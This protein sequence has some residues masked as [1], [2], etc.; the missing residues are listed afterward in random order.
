M[1]IK[2]YQLATGNSTY[3][4]VL[5]NPAYTVECSLYN[6]FDPMNAVFVVDGLYGVTN[7][8]EYEY[9]GITYFGWF[10]KHTLANGLYEFKVTSIDTIRMVDIVGGLSKTQFV[11]YSCNDRSR[12]MIVDDGRLPSSAIP[13]IAEGGYKGVNTQDAMIMLTMHKYV[14]FPAPA[15]GSSIPYKLRTNPF[16]ESYLMDLNTYNQLV[17]GLINNVGSNA[18]LFGAFAANVQKIYVLP[19]SYRSTDVGPLVN[20]I[21]FTALSK[22]PAYEFYPDFQSTT[23]SISGTCYRIYVQDDVPNSIAKTFSTTCNYEFT[24][25]RQTKT[26]RG[27]LYVPTVG[28]LSFSYVDI[29]NIIKNT[30]KITSIGHKFVVAPASGEI[31][32]TL[33]INGVEVQNVFANATLPMYATFPGS[34]PNNDLM[35][36]AQTLPSLI[37]HGKTVDPSMITAGSTIVEDLFGYVTAPNT[38]S[39]SGDSLDIAGMKDAFYR[40][41]STQ[42]SNGYSAVIGLPYYKI[43]SLSNHILSDGF[44]KTMN[45]RFSGLNDTLPNEII[46]V[47]ESQFDSGLHIYR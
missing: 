44:V 1:Q 37:P 43:D 23:V 5:P 3:R 19:F 39:A 13:K 24:E 41:S 32:A 45:C 11:Q 4:P 47:A 7:Y 15:I 25:S 31:R 17:E 36:V 10:E 27:E 18:D 28:T 2:L 20:E 34:V 26:F 9:S 16:M 8:V 38:S 12:I 14:K 42:C 33:L 29:Y 35:N 30:N 46:N 22:Y 40:F 21:T 6:E